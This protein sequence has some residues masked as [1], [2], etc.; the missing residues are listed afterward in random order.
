[1]GNGGRGLHIYNTINVND[2]FNTYIG[3]L[4]N[5][6][7]SSAIT[8]G[9]ETDAQYNPSLAVSNNVL[10]YGNLI[11]PLN[12]PNTTDS[13]STYTNNVILGGTQSV[14]SGNTNLTS[15]GT[16]YFSGTINTS[17][18][19]S[20]LA[21]SSFIPISANSFSRQTNSTGYQALANSPRPKSSWA[22]GALELALPIRVAII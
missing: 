4:T 6:T 15:T 10:H 12:T 8:N 16:A 9:V 18:L 21:M 20:N 1:V 13:V 14:P 2:F 3:N 7:D 5:V 22:A 17:T 19:L 11:C